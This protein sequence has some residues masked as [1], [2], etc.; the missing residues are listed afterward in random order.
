MFPLGE[1]G[2]RRIPVPV[3]FPE[4]GGPANVYVIDEADGGVALFDSGIG[5][6]VGET[7]LREGMQALGL[8]FR[9]VRRIYLSHGHID[10]YGLA[11]TLSE[12]SGAPVFIHE[13]DRAKV[14]RPADGVAASR[15]AWRAYLTRL[16]L[17]QR[18]IDQISRMHQLHQSMARPI[19]RTQGVHDGDRLHFKRFSATVQHAPGHTPGLTCLWLAEHGI[20]FSDDHLLEKVSPNPL[21]EIGPEGD[22]NKFRA[23]ATYLRTL[24]ATRELDVKLVL[25]G[26]DVP[27]H[28]PR[29]VIDSLLG[30]YEKR[31][32]KMLA[33]L[34]E[35]PQTALELVAHIFPRAT[36]AVLFLTLS[37]IVGNLEVLEDK[38][39]VAIDRT[40]P[41]Y[42]WSL[43]R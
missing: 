8:A 11:R 33:K 21:L 43:T 36:N 25:P 2:I 28:E 20:L 6:P 23:L 34:E 42:R 19:E 27:F 41:S 35:G 5:T 40:G 32:A 17:E 13:A 4:A 1:L 14:E 12:E 39:L 31:Q 16:G 15:E 26:H 29:R 10:H 24:R 30:F 38:G 7:S 22:A 9:D 37:E 18:D 3:P